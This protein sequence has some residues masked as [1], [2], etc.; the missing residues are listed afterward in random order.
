MSMDPAWLF[1]NS[2]GVLTIPWLTARETAALI[3]VAV[4]LLFFRV[5]S[6]TLSAGV[7]SGLDRLRSIPLGDAG[8]RIARRIEVDGGIRAGR[9]CAG[10]GVV[11]GGGADVGAGAASADRAGRRSAWVV[12]VCAAMRPLYFPEFEAR[13]RL[14]L[15]V[16][17][18]LIAAGAA[19]EL[20]RYRLGTHWAW[21]VPVR[22]RAADLESEL[23]SVHQSHSE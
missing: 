7:G 19:L 8:E 12:M 5:F 4:S 16:A 20:L 23:A 14:G 1:G 3:V 13:S 15:D 18:R 2:V 6:G 9:L 22:R 10:D 11:C 21:S 17:C